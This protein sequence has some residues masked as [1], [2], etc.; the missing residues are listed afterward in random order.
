MIR[1]LDFNKYFLSASFIPSGFE[2]ALYGAVPGLGTK[3]TADLDSDQHK[4]EADSSLRA[5][6]TWTSN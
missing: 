6:K 2:R 5:L 3:H 1:N 4:G